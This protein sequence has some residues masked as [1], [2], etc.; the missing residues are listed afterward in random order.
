[1]EV[2]WDRDGLYSRFAKHSSRLLLHLGSSGPLKKDDSFHTVKTSYCSAMLAELYMSRNVCLHVVPKKI[3]CDRGTQFTLH[4]WQQLHEALD[5]HLNFSSAYHP[6]ID[7][8]TERTNQI[9]EDMLRACALQDKSGWNKR[10]PY[11]DSP[12]TTTINPVWRCH[13]F[14]HSMGGI[15]ELRCTGTSPSK[16]RCLIHIFC[17]KLKRTSEWFGRTWWQRSPDIK[18]M[19]T[20]EEESWVLKWEIMFTWRCHWSEESEGSESRES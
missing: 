16:G 3:V 12:T 19:P 7:G 15:V 18:V 13:S 17:L 8:Q 1:M 14:K 5:T 9:L 11:A 6:Q 4:F 20:P 10:L 2:G